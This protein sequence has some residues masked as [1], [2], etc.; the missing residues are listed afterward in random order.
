[1]VESTTLFALGFSLI[2]IGV[3]IVATAAILVM[4][5]QGKKEKKTRTAGIIIIGPVPIIFGSDKKDVK[6]LLALSTGLT[7]AL[8]VLLIVYYFLWR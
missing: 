7:V 5:T 6:I 8:I 1:M 3:L 4:T 2:L